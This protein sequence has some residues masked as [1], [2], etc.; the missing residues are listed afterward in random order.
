MAEILSPLSLLSNGKTT[1][2]TNGAVHTLANGDHHQDMSSTSTR[3]KGLSLTEY[4]VN[5][6]RPVTRDGVREY[7][8]IP[9]GDLLADGTPDVRIYHIN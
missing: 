7:P 2:T 4:A 8:S 5:S 3:T 6:S 9:E 1:E